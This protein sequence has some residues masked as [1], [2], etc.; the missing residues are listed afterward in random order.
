MRIVQLALALQNYST[1]H[2]CVIWDVEFH[3]K[4]S[5]DTAHNVD[6]AHLHLYRSF[7]NEELLLLNILYYQIKLGKSLNFFISLLW[8]FPLYSGALEKPISKSS[9]QTFDSIPELNSVESKMPYSNDMLW[10][11][12]LAVF[13]LSL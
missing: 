1:N 7:W 4:I 8:H 9:I 11:L 10:L 3:R 13:P 12:C 5:S 6:T 2:H